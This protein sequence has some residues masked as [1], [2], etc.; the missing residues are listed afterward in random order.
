M[1]LGMKSGI[2]YTI[3]SLITRG[4]AIITVPIFTRLMSTSQIGTVNLYNSSY[5]MISVITT[6]SLT[7]GGY[8]LA[9]KEFPSER[10]EYESS[11]LSITTLMSGFI[12]IIYF[13]SPVYWNK[14][15][16]IPGPLI[17]MMLVGFLVAPARDFWM[18]RQRYEYKYKLSGIISIC[19]AIFASVFS[20]IVVIT[21]SHRHIVDSAIGRLVSNY[22]IVYGVALFF[23]FFLMFRGKT[24]YNKRFWKFS[25]SLSVPLVG[26]S[27]AKQ[28]LDV[29]D[30]IMI[31]KLIG[32]GAV[33]IY[34]TL[35]SVSSIS[36]IAWSAINAS[37][38][39]YLFKNI[40]DVNQK[41]NINKI[42]AWLLGLYAVIAVILTLFS[43]E[44]VKILATPKYYD[45]IYIMPPIASGVFLTS[46]FGMYSNILIYYKKTKSIMIPAVVAAI[47]NIGLNSIFIPLFGYRTAAYST[48]VAYAILALMEMYISTHVY[49]NM[50]GAATMVYG[51][52]LILCMSIITLLL[53]LF[54]LFLYG[55]TILRYSIAVLLLF[56]LIILSTYI[57]REN[58]P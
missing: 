15:V 32:K 43:P 16:G 3:S 34:G 58:K 11:V 27:I 28:V 57:F 38:V 9:M 39:P 36:L 14:L 19:T 20:I 2:V 25:L 47:V 17:I 55:H 35:Y 48:L 10:N 29:S 26:Y 13:V 24:F 4:L 41:R 40:D 31:G 8:Q 30:Q 1:P 33:G 12:A 37:F 46:V 23:W 49:K 45:A 44:I 53:N 51:N 21:M 6:L 50:T 54:G 56:V 7:S 5:A 22:I 52:S 18:A 42:A